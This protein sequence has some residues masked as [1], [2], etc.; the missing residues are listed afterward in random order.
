MVVNV[1]DA[2][3]LTARFAEIFEA[4]TVQKYLADLLHHIAL[5]REEFLDVLAIVFNKLLTEISMQAPS[6]LL[7][8]FPSF[9][10]LRN[11]AWTAFENAIVDELR[12]TT[13][14][15]NRLKELSRYIV[16]REVKSVLE[17]LI[18]KEDDP[19]RQR[20]RQSILDAREGIKL[21][22]G[23]MQLLENWIGV[24]PPSENLNLVCQKLGIRKTILFGV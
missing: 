12:I 22:V 20:I 17:E 19:I 8:K 13:A 23:I 2:N 1:K 9:W 11:Y 6:K 18:E 4:H 24:T 14:Q 10:N 5:D 21:P 3:T 7:I 16:K 15:K